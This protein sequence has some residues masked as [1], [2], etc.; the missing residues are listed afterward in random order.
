MPPISGPK[1]LV[2]TEGPSFPGRSGEQKLGHW[3]HKGRR[4]VKM[5]IHGA[6]HIANITCRAGIHEFSHR[7]GDEFPVHL[8]DSGGKI[9]YF[10]DKNCMIVTRR[11]TEHH[12]TFI[13]SSLV[14]ETR[15]C[16]TIP[17]LWKET[18]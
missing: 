3:G 17:T 11:A 18:S 6:R 15:H 5:E 9:W 7:S 12:K 8:A 14:V 1:P 13:Q 2:Q 10:S 4:M 16:G